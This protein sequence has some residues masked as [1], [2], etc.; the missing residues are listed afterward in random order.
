MECMECM[1]CTE[2]LWNMSLEYGDGRRGMFSLFGPFA[3]SAPERLTCASSQS[4][5]SLV[6]TEYGVVGSLYCPRLLSSPA[7]PYGEYFLLLVHF[8]LLP[9]SLLCMILRTEL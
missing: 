6:C 2:Y 3:Q 9:S 7:T 1:E 5:F 8:C 4:H